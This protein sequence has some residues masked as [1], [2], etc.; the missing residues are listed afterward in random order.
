MDAVEAVDKRAKFVMMAGPEMGL[1]ASRAWFEPEQTAGSSA[2]RRDDKVD[3]G[4]IT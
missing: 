1:A 2:S 3:C 4:G